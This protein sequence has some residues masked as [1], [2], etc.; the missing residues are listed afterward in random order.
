MVVAAIKRPKLQQS[1][2]GVA[3]CLAAAIVS[4]S[5]RITLLA[6]G[7]AYPN[8]MGGI[9]VMSS[10][11]HDIIGLITLTVA[12]LPI[13]WWMQKL[14]QP[15][16][17]APF[18]ATTPAFPKLNHR[19]S[20]TVGMAFA[21][22]AMLI[23]Q[24]PGKPVDVAHP[25][26]TPILPGHILGVAGKD[27]PLSDQERNYFRRYGGGASRKVYNDSA[28]L[29]VQSSAPLR[30]LHAPDECLRGSGHKVQYLGMT[31]NRIPTAVYRSIDPL[32]QAWRIRVSFVSDDGQQ[33]HSVA[34]A[35]WHWMQH[36]GS[37]WSQVQR[38]TPWSSSDSRADQFDEAV[39]RALDIKIQNTFKPTKA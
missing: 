5:L 4:N 25:S 28:L 21:V 33:F 16:A 29:V 23:L 13:L 3:I 31:R 39:L 14:A 24:L 19:T 27:D 26:N 11:W 22:T 36:P 17:Y 10:P 34:A 30:H 8:W 6:L 7:I 38:I 37:T 2:I 9:N 32:G 20:L 18:V 15:L 35:V 1:I 12:L